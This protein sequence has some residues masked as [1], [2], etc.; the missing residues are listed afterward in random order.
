MRRWIATSVGFF[1]IGALVA[2]IVALPV[3]AQRGGEETLVSTDQARERA[4]TFLVDN[5]YTSLT[6]GDIFTFTNHFV[7]QVLDPATGTG[8]FELLVSHDG[9]LVHPAPTM[10]WNTDDDLMTT[11]HTQMMGQMPMGAGEGMMRQ[12]DMEPGSM[13]DADHQGHHQG[14]GT[15]EGMPGSG[16]LQQ[17][18]MP[19]M[20]ASMGMAAC[21]LSMG[22]ATTGSELAEPL[23]VDGARSAAQT[24]LDQQGGDLITGNATQYPG[25]ITFM[26]TTANG[27]L[28]GMLSVQT[29]TGA[30]RPLDWHGTVAQ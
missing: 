6:V 12:G 14:Q 5:G 30:I 3:A 8:A 27:E 7:V 21:G 15:M 25:Y 2:L 11:M 13:S 17:Q 24:W 28:E 20:S 9:T 29:S 10:M 16:M 22:V 23:T 19:M 4:T 1:V 26:T 18:R